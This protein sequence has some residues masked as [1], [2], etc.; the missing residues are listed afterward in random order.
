MFNTKELQ[1]LLKVCDRTTVTGLENNQMMV[2]VATKLAALQRETN[3][4]TL[5]ALQLPDKKPIVPNKVI[6]NEI[7]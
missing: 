6:P 7:K 2:N 4:A 3:T 5:R 1:F